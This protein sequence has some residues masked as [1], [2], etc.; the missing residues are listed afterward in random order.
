MT[1][2]SQWRWGGQGAFLRIFWEEK[3]PL[4][5]RGETDPAPERGW[6]G[7]GN[8]PCPESWN[9]EED[10]AAIPDLQLHFPTLQ[11]V[12]SPF[13]KGENGGIGSG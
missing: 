8:F 2:V 9:G 3:Y 7:R 4:G 11:S 12:I 5:A 6:G 13:G 10:E 1:W